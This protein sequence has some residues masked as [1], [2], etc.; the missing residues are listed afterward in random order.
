MMSSRSLKGANR[1]AGHLMVLVWDVL[2]LAAISACL[3][4]AMATPALA[5]VDPSVMTYTIQA[6]AAVAVALSAVL[7][8]AFRRTRKAL[9]RLLRI[10]EGAGRVA[11]PAVSRIDPASKPAADAAAREA[12]ASVGASARGASA[13]R[14][15]GLPW[16]RRIVLALLACVFLALTMFVVAPLEL[17][18]GSSDSLLFGVKQVWQVVVVAGLAIAA[19]SGLAISAIRGRVFDVVIAIAVALGV[20]AYV[21]V[22]FMNSSLP[23]ADGNLVDW[24]QFASITGI[25]LLVWA[26]IV[27]VLV[28]L[29]VKRPRVGRAAAAALSAALIVVQVA[30]VVDI[31][32][33]AASEPESITITEKG[34]FDVSGKKNVVCFVLDM[35]D[36][37]DAKKAYADNPNMLDGLDGF[38]WYQNSTGSMI[39]TRYGIP[40]LLTGVRP[41]KGE[42]AADF[43]SSM[44][45]DSHFLDDVAAQGYTTDIYSDSADWID[46]WREYLGQHAENFESNSDVARSAL[47]WQ[48]TLRILYQ[49][50][51]Y[52]DMPWIAKPFFWFYTDQLNQGMVSS[53]GASSPDTTPYAID[54]PAYFQK[55]KESGLTVNGEN[56]SFRFIHLEGTHYPFIM[57]AEGNR[58][59]ES[60]DW[61]SQMVGAFKIVRTYLGELKRLGLYDSTTVVIT[62]D[63]GTWYLTPDDLDGVST[64]II[65]VK[66][67]QSAEADS[68]PCQISQQP[69][70]HYDLQATMLKGMGASQDVLDHYG[71]FNQAIEDR[72]DS[73]DR[74]RYYLMT[75]SNGKLDTSWREYEISGDSQDFANWRLDGNEWIITDEDAE[76]IWH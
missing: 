53:E 28:A 72:S 10:D 22:L 39:P 71:E 69:A 51:L 56:A 26:A 40:S 11:E 32:S 48:G 21:Q 74:L 31:V 43:L 4:T 17:V 7:G 13:R 9:V 55:L 38:T 60:N 37:A 25:S 14:P 54:D 63:H 36:T 33:K 6:L 27:I 8:V 73:A 68:V 2:G 15:A 18:A 57:D 19:V 67:A 75:T 47:D 5:Y 30:G 12:L 41:Q 66:P 1:I 44:Y 35:T 52:R 45:S 42:D 58:V 70:S 23:V 49:C 29:A 46:G 64:P 59:A 16:R 61:E 50:A 62:A 20:G 65:F 24:T 76:R 34:L 3:L